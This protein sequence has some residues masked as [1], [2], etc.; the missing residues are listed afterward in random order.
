MTSGNLGTRDHHAGIRG[1]IVVT[2][3]DAM[4]VELELCVPVP[5]GNQGVLLRIIDTDGKQVGVLRVGRATAEW[6]K[7][8]RTVK[9]RGKKFPVTK[10][11]E[12]LNT[13]E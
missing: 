5:L 9:G 6:M 10:L 3:G 7:G 4:K 1:L 12:F 13:L 2:M 8:Q 11:V